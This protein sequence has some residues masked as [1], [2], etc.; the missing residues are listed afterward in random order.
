VN[1]DLKELFE[2]AKKARDR[3]YSPYSGQKV[4]SAVRLKSGKVYAGCNV[5]NS[6]YG[7]TNCAERAAIQ[8]AIG[9][10]GPKIEIVE[11]LVVTDHSPPWPPCGLCRQVI[12]EFGTNSTVHSADLASV[13]TSVSFR[14]LYPSAFTPDHLK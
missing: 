7:A 13:R 2:A 14:E 8:T 6:S 9:A 3:A 4:G 10:E 11:V 12:S 1:T 5:E